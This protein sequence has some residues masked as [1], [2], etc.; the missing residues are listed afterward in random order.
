MLRI[1]T[2]DIPYTPQE[3]LEI[4]LPQKSH[5]LL[6]IK[7]KSDYMYPIKTKVSTILKRYE[8]ECHP[9]LPPI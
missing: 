6:K 3:Q 8:W 2:K 7:P 4:V 9:I 1:K 5:Y